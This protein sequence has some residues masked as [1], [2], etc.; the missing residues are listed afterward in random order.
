MNRHKYGVVH[1]IMVTSATRLGVNTL[2][3]G[4]SGMRDG[5]FT[6]N[7]WLLSA[8]FHLQ[9]LI[10]VDVS[11]FLTFFPFFSGSK[12]CLV[13]RHPLLTSLMGREERGIF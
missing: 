9:I 1:I 8:S 6:C 12:F 4:L 13:H 2:C 10:C 3:V 7:D 5:V 11:L